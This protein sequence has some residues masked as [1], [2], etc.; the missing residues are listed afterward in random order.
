[1]TGRTIAAVGGRLRRRLPALAVSAL[2]GVVVVTATGFIVRAQVEEVYR[3]QDAQLGA[4]SDARVDQV[5]AWR[6][7]RSADAR[8]SAGSSL[9]ADAVNRWLV[10][11][12]PATGREIVQTLRLVRE[13]YQY[14][15]VRL[16]TPP[17]TCLRRRSGT[18][19]RLDRPR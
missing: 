7:E 16:L 15:D 6:A 8:V 19:R 13:A 1:M 18:T 17:A 9:F 4:L 3:A 5:L 11:R 10:G 2:I 12:D 14:E